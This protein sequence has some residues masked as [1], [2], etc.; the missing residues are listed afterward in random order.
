DRSPV[1]V[2]IYNFPKR[3]GITLGAELMHRLAR[4]E[5]MIGLKDSSGSSE[6]VAA[7]AQAV[8][9]KLKYVGDETLLVDTLRAGWSGSISGAANSIP[10]WLSRVV[11]EW[12]TNRES[13]EA[14]F[15]LVLPVLKALR[16]QPQPA[17]NKAVLKRLRVLDSA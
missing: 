5:R 1:D 17:T 10:Q 7:Y 2:L 9:G 15:E 11:A 6:N 8:A 16:S 3:T 13:A 4:H 14:K 12:E